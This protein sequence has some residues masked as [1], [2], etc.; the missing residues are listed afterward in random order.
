M[1]R[2][3]EVTSAKVEVRMVAEALGMV[4]DTVAEAAAHMVEVTI[5]LAAEVAAHM[6]AEVAAHTVVEVAVHT[7]TEVAVPMAGEV[8]THTVIE[9]A[10]QMAVTSGTGRVISGTSLIRGH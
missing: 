7:A 2:A 3:E 9:T 6:A 5:H 8:A 1:G 10:V 4:E